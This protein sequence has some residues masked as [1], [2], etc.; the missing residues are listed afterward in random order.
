MAD[1]G[2]QER[3]SPPDT[4]AVPHELLVVCDAAISM[5]QEAESVMR[6]CLTEG[7]KDARLA[8]QAGRLISAFTDLVNRVVDLPPS[9]VVDEAGDL[10]RYHQRLLAETVEYAYSVTAILDRRSSVFFSDHLGEPALRLRRL[11]ELVATHVESQMAAESSKLARAGDNNISRVV[12][13][14]NGRAGAILVQCR[15][16]AT[17]SPP[18]AS[19]HRRRGLVRS[20]PGEDA[21]V[22]GAPA[23]GAGRGC[24][25]WSQSL[26][27]WWW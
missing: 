26:R 7:P 9:E 15:T 25:R 11:R 16:V 20:D 19:T 24:W 4:E 22:R 2:G 21:G 23:I 12:I 5:Q 27:S 10:L 1:Q 14:S 13:S 3:A 8:R 18:R 6:A 17:V